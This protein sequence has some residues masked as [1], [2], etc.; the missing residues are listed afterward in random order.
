MQL[1][2]RWGSAGNTTNTLVVGCSLPYWLSSSACASRGECAMILRP[3]N[4][5]SPADAV[6]GCAAAW[7]RPTANTLLLAEDL[8]ARDPALAQLRPSQWLGLPVLRDLGNQFGIC[9][10]REGLRPN[11]WVRAWAKAPTSMRGGLVGGRWQ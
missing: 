3:R 10:P 8:G 11:H 5:A 7:S 6:P 4:D 2:G 9:P 1:Q